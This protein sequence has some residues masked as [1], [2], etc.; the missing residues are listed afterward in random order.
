MLEPAH[1]VYQKQYRYFALINLIE[2][3]RQIDLH[4]MVFSLFLVLT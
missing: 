2:V 1:G 4:V 3:E